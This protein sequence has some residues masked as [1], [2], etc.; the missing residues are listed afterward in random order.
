MDKW[1][2]QC[3]FISGWDD[4]G[5]TD[6]FGETSL[7]DSEKDANDEI[8]QMIKFCQEAA[9]RGD[10]EDAPERSTFRAVLYKGKATTINTELNRMVCLLT[11]M[12]WV[13]LRHVS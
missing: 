2:V 4:A 12:R 7:F 8:D 13:V 6:S 1:Y 5:W 9:A 11:Y 3:N 10:M